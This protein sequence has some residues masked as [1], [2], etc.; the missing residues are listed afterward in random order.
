MEMEVIKT[1]EYHQ[2]IIFLT[3]I[4]EKYQLFYRSSGLAG[5]GSKGMVLPHLLL[6]ANKDSSPDGLG[7]WM[8]FGWIV[9]YYVYGG[10][11]AEYRY[12]NRSEFP[13]EMHPYLDELEAMD[14]TGAEV[15]P[16]PRVINNYCIDYIKGIEDYVDWKDMK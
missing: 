14:T 1:W 4:G 15:E 7:Q 10:R 6:K 13:K 11:Y 8:S 3:K 5:Y 16:D 2:R 12:K 9:K